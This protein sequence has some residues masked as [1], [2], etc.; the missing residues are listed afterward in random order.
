MPIRP[1]K[2]TI[3]APQ[4]AMLT[5]KFFEN[6]SG[7]AIADLYIGERRLLATNHPATIAAAIYAMGRKRVRVE[8][9]AGTRTEDLEFLEP[10]DEGPGPVLAKL[11]MDIN[12][13]LYRFNEIASTDSER[14]FLE[15][16]EIFA[17]DNWHT[18]TVQAD[19]HIRAAHHHLPKDLIARPLSTPDPEGWAKV[20]K[21]RNGFIYFP[22]C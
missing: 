12:P 7:V 22:D 13:R 6:H 11:R 18:P 3:P 2:S 9:S 5:L 1:G 16:L 14:K 21:K 15:G 8:T 4:I 20:L 19:E 10:G 17:F